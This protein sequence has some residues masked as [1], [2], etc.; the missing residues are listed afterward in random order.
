M[1]RIAVAICC[2]LLIIGGGLYALYWTNSVCDQVMVGLKQAADSLERTGKDDGAGMEQ[3]Y[4]IWQRNIPIFST[5]VIHDQVDAV[6]GAFQRARAFLEFETY[7]EY[8]AEIMQLIQL[9]DFVRD[10]DRPT[11]RSIF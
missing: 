1:W 4:R 2:I 11:L 6:S 3:A 9:I 10:F 7:D 5:F 8:N